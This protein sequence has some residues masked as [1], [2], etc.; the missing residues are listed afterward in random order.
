[1][2]RPGPRTIG[3]YSEEFKAAAVRLSQLEGV[4]VQDVAHTLAIHPFMLSR[5]RK[6]VREGRIVAKGVKL[7]EKVAAELK[8]LRKVK[9][10]Y[11]RLKVEHDLLTSDRVHFKKTSDIFECID[12]QRGRYPV[13]VMCRVYGVS[14]CGYYAWR[15]RGPSQRALEDEDLVGKIQRVHDSSRQT[16]GSPRVHE[17]LVGQGEEVGLRRVAR[18]MQEDQIRG[19]SARLY[20][21]TPGTDRFFTSIGNQTGSRE[22]TG[23]DQVWVGDVTY[24]KLGV[25]W[26]YLAIVMDWYS[27]RVLGWSFGRDRTVSLTL[28]ALNQ[29]VRGRGGRVPDV[30]HNDRGV[31]YLGHRYR[32]RLAGLGVAQSVN[33]PRR[34]NDNAHMESFFGSLKADCYHGVHFSS[35]TNLRGTLGEYMA[36]YNH[37]RLHTSI[38]CRAPVQFERKKA[39]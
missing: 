4:A 6:E 39:A 23:C 35:A 27:R 26:F 9:R 32:K 13:S 17:A 25:T 12:Q 10:D 1:M 16:Y 11:E 24:L 2:P 30:F 7:D 37:Q 33:R 5:W 22:V 29:A 15:S 21:R 14:R 28:R 18:L 8:E 19:R 34:M 38:G 36:F 31:E 3:Q 20:R